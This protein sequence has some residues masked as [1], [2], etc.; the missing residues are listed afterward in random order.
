VKPIL[1]FVAACAVITAC[2][3]GGGGTSG[4]NPKNLSLSGVKIPT[5]EVVSGVQLMCS[6]AKQAHTDPAG[7]A[8]PFYAAPHNTMH[9][10]V[11]VL[12]PAHRAAS[13]KLLNAMYVYESD[14]AATPPPPATGTDA[15]NLLQAAMEGLT[16]LQVTPP[17]CPS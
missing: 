16:A 15:D 9:Q 10:L 12:H 1:A 8:G 14:I 3:G 5:S 7:S 17:T 4:P 13:D 6:V 2:G 11:T